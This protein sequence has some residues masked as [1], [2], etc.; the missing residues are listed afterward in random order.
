MHM[1]PPHSLSVLQLLASLQQQACLAYRLFVVV[2]V[3]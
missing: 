2:S 1:A 3:G